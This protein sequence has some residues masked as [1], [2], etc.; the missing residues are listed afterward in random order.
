M[1]QGTTGGLALGP[2]LRLPGSLTWLPEGAE[3]QG[4]VGSAGHVMLGACLNL[5]LC[6]VLL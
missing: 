2:S 4:L 3:P 6:S 1:I 5:P